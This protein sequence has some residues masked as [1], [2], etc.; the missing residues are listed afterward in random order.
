MHSGVVEQVMRHKQP[1]LQRA[2]CNF[3]RLPFHFTLG[4]VEE[5]NATLASQYLES[6]RLV[7]IRPCRESAEDSIY[8]RIMSP[9]RHH[10][11]D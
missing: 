9:D 10:H 6:L 3:G 4:H 2:Y 7:A 5:L 1:G 11:V 8:L